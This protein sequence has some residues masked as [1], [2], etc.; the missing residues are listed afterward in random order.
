MKQPQQALA[1]IAMRGDGGVGKSAITIQFMRQ[2]FVEDYDP[3][4]EDSFRKTITLDKESVGL[5]VFDTA[6]KTTNQAAID[7]PLPCDTT[8]PEEYCAL[9][10]AVIRESEGFMLVFSITSRPSFQDLTARR[11]QIL[12]VRSYDLAPIVICANKIDL[13]SDVR[14]VTTDEA[15]ALAKSWGADYFETSAKTGVNVEEAFV[16]LTR[17]ILNPPLIRFRVVQSIALLVCLGH[18]CP[19]SV[20][21]TLP[22]DV[23][24]LIARIVLKSYSDVALWKP[25]VVSE[26]SKREKR[27]GKKKCTL[28]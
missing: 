17:S 24:A 4:V 20:L 6:G 7:Q 14:E 13:G 26:M 19:S 18:R 16:C 5:D 27:N 9:L 15:K 21:S 10:D 28:Q 22:R 25:I 1:K 23:C 3:T 12:R 11:D 8:G 2:V